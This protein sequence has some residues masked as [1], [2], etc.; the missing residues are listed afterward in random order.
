MAIENLKVKLQKKIVQK[1]K[2]EPTPEPVEEE[3]IK[4]ARNDPV[5]EQSGRQY[6]QYM[7]D[8]LNKVMTG[9]ITTDDYFTHY[10]F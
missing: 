2:K 10:N 4:I 5:D 9:D 7:F 1:R 3:P 8:I 6:N